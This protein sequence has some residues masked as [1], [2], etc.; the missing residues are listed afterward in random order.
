[1][2]VSSVMCHALLSIIKLDGKP[3]KPRLS[4]PGE[5]KMILTFGEVDHYIKIA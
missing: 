1:M 5:K 2:C 4:V 3:S